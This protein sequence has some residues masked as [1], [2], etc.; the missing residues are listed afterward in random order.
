MNE[1]EAAEEVERIM[2]DIDKNNSGSIDYSEFVAASINRAKLL[3]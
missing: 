3:S 1:N 2:R